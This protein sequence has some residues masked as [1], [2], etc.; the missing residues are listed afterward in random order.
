MHRPG[1]RTGTARTN[2][3]LMGCRNSVLSLCSDTACDIHSMTND[4]TTHHGG[5]VLLIAHPVR[6]PRINP[7]NLEPKTPKIRQPPPSADA[8][9]CCRRSSRARFVRPPRINS[10]NLE[11]ETPKIRQPPPSADAASC[12]RRS[13]RARCASSSYQFRQPRTRNLENPSTAPISRCCQLLPPLLS[14]ACNAR[15]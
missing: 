14:R 2:P 9:S 6:H 15:L 10:I 1:T 11:P 5:S 12:C 8:A 7:V 13:S 4:I 3:N